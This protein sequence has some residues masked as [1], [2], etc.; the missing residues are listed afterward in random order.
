MPKPKSSSRRWLDRHTKDP[1][2]QRA[3]R[4]GYRS[5]AAYKLLELQRRDKLIRPGMR[6]VDLGAAPGSWS[7]VILPLVGR[8]G[9]VIAL[10]RLALDPIPGVEIIQGDFH[11]DEVLSHLI[12]MLNGES[13]DLV[14]SDMAPNVTGMKAIDQPRLILLAELV[15]EF[16]QSMLKPGGSMV[17]KVFHGEGFDE[18]LA[19]TRRSFRQ[20][21]SR[22]P[23]ASR[24]QS[25]EL[26]LVAKGLRVEPT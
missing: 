22:K 5:R 17:V 26:Y 8:R 19:A 11:T 3:Q 20:V 1:Y 14:L 25:R 12:D 6:V 15:L 16:T 10:D 21:V 13:L 24:S 2:V 18:Y 9:R 23:E 7:Q 4:E